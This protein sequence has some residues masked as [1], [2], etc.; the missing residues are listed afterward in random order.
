VA[1]L[2]YNDIERPR[3]LVIEDDRE[4][5][6]LLTR[7]LE[8]AGYL[9]DP[10]G[11]G[12]AGL[13][14]GLTRE[15]DVMIIDRGLP[16]ID[17]VDLTGRLRR[18]GITTPVLILTAYGSVADRVSGLDAGAE[19]YVVKPFEI[20]ELLARLR[21][22]RRRHDGAA[23][24]LQLGG[25]GQL[26]LG[27]RVVRRSDGSEVEL[28]SREAALLQV[29]AARPSRVFSRDELRER[30]F[31]AAESDSIVDTYVHYLRRKLG[32]GV[33]RT[34]RGFGYRAGAL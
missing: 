29:L 9:V 23:E 33:V 25:G 12:Q 21:A 8:D 6:E 32:N 16:G 2:P 22:L 5:R 13:H 4:L 3:I 14:R 30:V 34:V 31:E 17:G 7:L 10:A 1:E 24:V 28:S 20:D 11:D 26:D 15:Y 19:D 27:A 18:Q